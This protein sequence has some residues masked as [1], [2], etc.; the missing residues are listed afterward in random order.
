V[1]TPTRSARPTPPEADFTAEERQAI[2]ALRAAAAT[3]TPSPALVAHEQAVQDH[4][5]ETERLKAECGVTAAHELE[6]AA[7]ET[8]SQVQAD[9]VDTPAKTLAGLIFKARYAATHYSYEYDEEVMESIVDDLLAMP[10]G[11]ADV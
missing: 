3:R 9:L 11:F 4:E 10:E 2:D 7:H 1:P 8:I 6:D 5:R